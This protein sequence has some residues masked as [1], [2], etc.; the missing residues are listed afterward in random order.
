MPVQL[1]GRMTQKLFAVIDS[2]SE[3]VTVDWG[4]LMTRWALDIIGLAGF[5]KMNCIDNQWYKDHSLSIT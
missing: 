5:G 4:N 1:F 2:P 3:S